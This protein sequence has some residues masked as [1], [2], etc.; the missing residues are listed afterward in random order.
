LLKRRSVHQSFYD[1]RYR[2]R[3]RICPGRRALRG[4][5]GYCQFFNMRSFDVYVYLMWAVVS[6]GVVRKRAFFFGFVLFRVS[7]WDLAYLIFNQERDRKRK[8]DI[9]P[10]SAS[11]DLI[12]RVGSSGHLDQTS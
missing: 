12:S 4:L 1:E 6:E 9:F 7:V 8:L 3:G 11:N 5:Q 10:G 2:V